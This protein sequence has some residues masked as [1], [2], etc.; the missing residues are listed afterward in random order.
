MKL[1]K[2]FLES[3]IG[4][5]IFSS[6]R[7]IQKVIGMDSVEPITGT[8]NYA[9]SSNIVVDPRSQERIPWM[10]KSAKDILRLFIRMQVREM[11]GSFHWNHLDV[12]TC[13][14][15]GK[16]FLRATLICVIRKL[17]ESGQYATLEEQHCFS[18][19]NAQC[20]KDNADI[21]KGTFGTLLNEEMKLIGEAKVIRIWLAAGDEQDWG[22]ATVTIG[23]QDETE[24]IHTNQ[25]LFAEV[26]IELWVAGDLKW[27]AAAFG[28]ENSSGHWCPWCLSPAKEW[29]SANHDS[30]NGP[31]WSSELLREYAEGVQTGRLKTSSQRKGVVT[32]AAIDY[33]GP[34]RIIFPIL[35]ATLGFG[36]DWMKSFIK[37]M[38]AASEAYTKE[39][40]EAE[41]RM[42]N[43]A[44]ALEIAVCK[45]REYK[46]QVRE[47]VKE[48]NN[49][50]RRRGNNALGPVQREVITS[51]L[52]RIN[53]EIEKLQE[54][55]DSCKVAK[56]TTKETFEREAS[57]DQ[58]SKAF[59][60]PIRKNIERILKKHGIDKGVR[61]VVTYRA[62]HVVS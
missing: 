8:F 56:E 55:V 13:I 25:T 42:G 16:G 12:S 39:Y 41:E 7:D 33:V 45:L 37:E 20:S 51:D 17:D 62:M 44:E 58:N 1:L 38:Q 36:N 49:A 19:G 9:G 2:R 46:A 6:P 48:G 40:L 34:D 30:N 52:K 60:Q 10:Y 28:K 43:A 4:L 57:K 27:I 18:V 23:V 21:V 53:E 24:V 26:P 50:L 59:G 5:K 32:V 15:H 31:F 14:D 11:H 61:L 47:L 22:K 3:E 54:E 29:S 35:H